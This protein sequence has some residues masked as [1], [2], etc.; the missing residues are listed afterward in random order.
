MKR[1]ALLCSIALVLAG[2]SKKPVEQVK[3]SFPDFPE[4]VADMD[5][6]QSLT[7]DVEAA[8]DEGA[9]V[10]W[11]CSGEACARLKTTPSSATFNAVGIT[12]KAV[13]TAVSKK[14]PSVT[15]SIRINV[16]LN[17]SPDM[18]CK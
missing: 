7:I 17:D 12:G 1:T 9:G 15:R 18:V 5:L 8:N 6:G 13:L 14:Q 2:C 4:N 11:S 3:L 10:T 16:K